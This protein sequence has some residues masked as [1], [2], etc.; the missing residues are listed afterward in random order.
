MKIEEEN[1]VVEYFIKLKPLNPFYFGSTKSFDDN[2]GSKDYKKP[3]FLKGNLYPQQTAILGMLRKKILEDN[4]ILIENVKRNNEQKNREKEYIGKI[5]NDLSES[6]FGKIENIS[7]VQIY[8]EDKPYYYY[9][10]NKEGEER[11]KFSQ[12]KNLT[13][14]NGEKR[15]LEYSPK[16]FREYFKNFESNKRKSKDEVFTEVIEFGID[17]QKKEGEDNSLFKKQRCLFKGKDVYFGFYA[18]L[19]YAGIKNGFVQLGDKHSIFYLEVEEK[20]KKDIGIAADKDNNLML[21]TSDMYIE[22]DD[23][24]ELLNSS[25]GIILKNNKF[26]FINDSNEKFYKNKKS[27]NLIK[28]GSILISNKK[29][30]DILENKKYENYKK[31]GFNDYKI[32]KGDE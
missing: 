27:Q 15:L 9:E 11:V 6:T 2:K 14:K 10:D 21:F 5:T 8:I 12:N 3:Y 13:N 1:R 23:L 30:I 18:V 16:N 32:I 7:S 28:R 26:K 29:I 20:K 24:N 19:Q 22:Q 4:G 25:E 31:V 17:K